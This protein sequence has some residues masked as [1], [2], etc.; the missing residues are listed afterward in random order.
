MPALIRRL[1]KLL[2]SLAV[3]AA[4]STT[5][6]TREADDAAVPRA[7]TP[8][9]V[10]VLSTS[11]DVRA[12][13]RMG[14]V[15]WYGT[16]GGL[17]RTAPGEPT[18]KYT[19]LD[20]LPSNLIRALLVV[21]SD[22][23]IATDASLVRWQRGD[24]K[25]T[26]RF[27]LENVTALSACESTA[28]RTIYASASGRGVQAIANGLVAPLRAE[29]QGN[30][31]SLACVPSTGS[32]YIGSTRGVFLYDGVRTIAVTGRF[33]NRPAFSLLF[34]PES[35]HLLVGTPAGV[36]RI[37]GTRITHAQVVRDRTVTN[38][39][40]LTRTNEGL[41]IGTS[42]SGS[43]RV[44]ARGRAT[45]CVDCSPDVKG[46][47]SAEPLIRS[48]DI[49]ALAAIDGA[50][51]VGTFDR[52][53]SILERGQR[54]PVVQRVLDESTGLT[55]SRINALFVNR[56]TQYATGLVANAPSLWIGTERGPCV[57]TKQG[58][59]QCFPGNHT[60]VI[61]SHDGY[62]VV[63][64]SDGLSFYDGQSW[65]T[66]PVPIRRVTSLATHRGHLMVGT[67]RGLHQLSL[68]R[69]QELDATILRTRTTASGLWADWITSVISDG[70]RLWIG[71]YSSGLGYIG[72]DDVEHVVH[73]RA[74]INPSGLV[75]DGQVVF[76]GLGD[77]VIIANRRGMLAVNQALPSRDVTSATMWNGQ[78]WVGTRAGLARIE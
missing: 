19:T 73:Q 1:S 41:L 63:G 64:D 52:G 12:V 22:L 48:N 59:L 53:I 24:P 8:R 33:A 49:S 54:A 29:I 2:A 66:P 55:S 37:V 32:V 77:G 61:T 68:S 76:G 75:H 74:W 46:E 70:D 15:T 35:S 6:R 47:M 67:A 51:Y 25:V 4:C 45:R 26:T 50:L 10:Q 13:A 56:M 72:A 30:V 57:L 3:L 39:H 44:D 21:D 78:L 60:Q 11:H 14:A 20:G 31:L 27:P 40:A 58:H 36:S 17:L 23:W 71:T 42:D 43:Y 18:T 38:V 28:A 9:V 16:T 62:I 5:G 7:W 65:R 69:A 34:E